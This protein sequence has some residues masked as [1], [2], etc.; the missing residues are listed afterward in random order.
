[1]AEEAQKSIT[2]AAVR[3]LE[4]VATSTDSSKAMESATALAAL[5]PD[6]KSI[7]VG[8]RS[9]ARSMGN[10]RFQQEI[11]ENVTA[12]HKSNN[13]A[14]L[15]IYAVAPLSFFDPAT[16]VACLVQFFYGDCVP[17]LNRPAKI[18]GRHLS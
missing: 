2:A 7:C 9:L 11:E 17:N 16:W 18:A 3:T 10:D 12:A 6:H 5:L 8:M 14:L 13:P 1:M 15:R 4:A